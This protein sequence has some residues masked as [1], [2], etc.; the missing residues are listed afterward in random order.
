MPTTDETAHSIT[1][2]V[3]S[4][5]VAT[6]SEAPAAAVAEP[7]KIVYAGHFPLAETPTQVGPEG[8][9]YD[10][11]DGARVV[12][13]E[14]VEGT[15]LWRIRLTDIDTGNI[16]FNVDV[17]GARVN[18]TKRYYV[19]F[20]LEVWVVDADP[21]S[22]VEPRSV[23][24][25]SMDLTDR[26][27]LIHQPPGTVGDS[28][29]WFTY[30]AEFAKKHPTARVTVCLSEH[31][32]PLVK[33]AYPHLNFVTQDE[34]KEQKLVDT[35][36]ASYALGVYFA[37]KECNHQPVDFRHVG[38]HKTAAYILGVEPIEVSPTLALEDES[39]PM[40]QRY[41]CIAVQATSAAKQW[42]NP[43]GWR[44]VVK[45]LKD[46]GYEVVC[47]DQKPEHG[48]GLKWTHIPH[49]TVD[50][51]GIS[52]MEAARYLRHCEF[53]VG[54]SSGLSWL[55]WAA[56][57]KC[58]LISGFSLPSTEFY[59]PYRI[60]NWHPCNG[61]WNDPALMFENQNFLWCPRHANT[62]R[63]FECTTQITGAHVIRV[64]KSIPTFKD[65]RETAQSAD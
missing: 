20:R 48:V 12:L 3:E 50:K 62:P 34:L 59:T 49:G 47:I 21:K 24:D 55:A 56:G 5:S 18:S 14:R 31:I 52:L 11:N 63:Q 43:Y 61:C 6:A 23:L 13:P 15:G 57:A 26:N 53:M 1:V 40:K 17:K 22:K 35:S 60:I 16:V 33:N 25:H 38:L 7:Q 44:E 2:K 45:F 9:L 28:F 19:R 65:V 51:T 46:S 27:V 30:T 39:R 32:I 36:Y 42:N 10:F 8:I 37:D 29:A 54:L 64:I 4:S 41:V 58:V